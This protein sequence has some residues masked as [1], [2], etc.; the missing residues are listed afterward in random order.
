M[1]F[2]HSDVREFLCSDCGKQFKRKDKLR[3]H[4]LSIHVKAAKKQEQELKQQQQQDHTLQ[5]TKEKTSSDDLPTEKESS[6]QQQCKPNPTDPLKPADVPISNAVSPSDY[7]RFIYKCHDC[8]LGFKRRGMLVNHMAKRHPQ[9][10]IDSVPELNL[11]I[12]KAQRYY[13][14]Q[15]CDKV[16]KSSSKRKAHILKYHPGMDLPM[17]SRQKSGQ[18]PEVPGL[19][20][21]SYSETVG[22]VT[23][24][25]QRCAWCHKQYASK[26]RLLQHQRKQ[27]TE[28]LRE[29]EMYN[30]QDMEFGVDGMPDESGPNDGY[31][32]QHGHFLTTMPT[33]YLS[34]NG[35]YETENKLLK[36]SS[37][38]LEASLKDDFHFYD[39]K[40]ATAASSTDIHQQSQHHNHH[41]SL[42]ELGDAVL[43]KVDVNFK[44]VGTDYVD[45][46][47]SSGDLN[48]LPQLF[49]EIDYMTLKPV[50]V[51]HYHS[52]HHQNQH[53]HLHQQ[54]QQHLVTPENP[55]K[56][57]TLT[58]THNTG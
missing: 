34:N 20:N 22:N 29:I 33:R 47:S 14:C 44:V 9:V 8:Q 42:D 40:G 12:L 24:H 3:E 35:G 48:R 17:S 16:Y 32:D 50:S 31:I 18:P 30:Q 52:D 45:T 28:H 43:S 11:P 23:T 39:D 51:D 56:K 7:Q 4:I 38:A 57:L 58:Y 49:D 46:T 55:A 6:N 25:P 41:S 37:A 26:A 54:Q 36:L 2:S 27:H 5:I 10:S 53:L 21:A 15:Y 19:P 1:F 13:Y